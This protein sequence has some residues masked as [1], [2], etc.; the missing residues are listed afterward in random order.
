MASLPVQFSIR[1][2][3]SVAIVV[4]AVLRFPAVGAVAISLVPIGAL[5][6]I[7]RRRRKHSALTQIVL[8]A[9]ILVP[10]YVLSLGPTQMIVGYLD[11]TGQKKT[12]DRVMHWR[13]AFYAPLRFSDD[14]PWD[15]LSRHYCFHWF[16]IGYTIA[17]WSDH[18]TS[19]EAGDEP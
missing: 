10:A 6:V 17:S 9:I 14:G 3:L 8:V 15:Y 16:C 1:T 12:L 13:D 19:N 2:L 7:G 4:A 11:T 5:L 18:V